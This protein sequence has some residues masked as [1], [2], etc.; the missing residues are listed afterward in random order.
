MSRTPLTRF[1]SNIYINKYNGEKI[2]PRSQIAKSKYFPSAVS[3][4]AKQFFSVS[5]IGYQVYINVIRKRYTT[6]HDTKD[7]TVVIRKS[8]WNIQAWMLVHGGVEKTG[9]SRK[10]SDDEIYLYGKSRSRIVYNPLSVNAISSI[11]SKLSNTRE[12]LR[13]GRTT[14]NESRNVEPFKQCL[15]IK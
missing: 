11:P 1:H 4:R 8:R 3:L 6:R 13:F 9:K 5:S 7:T 2:D 12:I 14:K 10:T 15:T